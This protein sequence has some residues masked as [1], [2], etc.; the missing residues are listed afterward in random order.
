MKRRFSR[1]LLE[2]DTEA[3]QSEKPEDG[4]TQPR[5]PE[6]D[7]EKTLSSALQCQLPHL[8]QFC[9]SIVQAAG[10][11]P[12]SAGPLPFREPKSRSLYY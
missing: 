11:S 7:D 6:G 8:L 10:S 1:H 2:G 4:V 3:R 9:R 5:V 12:P